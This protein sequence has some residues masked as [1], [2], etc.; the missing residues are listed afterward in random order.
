MYTKEVI[1]HFTNPRNVGEIENADG[2]GEA[3]NIRCGDMMTMY[4]KVGPKDGGEV[5]EDIKFMTLGCASAIATSSKATE[6]A[7]GKR[8]GEVLAISNMDIAKSL[9]GLPPIKMHCS[10]LASDAIKEAVYD[11]MRRSNQPIP[12][13]LEGEHERIRRER[14]SIGHLHG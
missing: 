6:L 14:E 8:I 7:K 10:V 5:V 2:V 13:R 4:I 12:E 11:Y 3:G 9:G 1:D